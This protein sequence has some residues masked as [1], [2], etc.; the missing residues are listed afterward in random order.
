MSTNQSVDM[1]FNTS[2]NDL[3][4]SVDYVHEMSFNYDNGN[5]IAITADNYC[6]L[7][8]CDNSQLEANFKLTTPGVKLCWNEDEKNKVKFS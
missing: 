8:N 4:K 5:L 3:L 7:W 1:T 2:F 6:F